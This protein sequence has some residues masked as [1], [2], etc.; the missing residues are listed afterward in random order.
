MEALDSDL[1]EMCCAAAGDDGANLWAHV[2]RRAYEAVRA[3]WCGGWLSGPRAVLSSAERFA[4]AESIGCPWRGRALMETAARAGAL[5]VLRAVAP[6]YTA[7]P[8]SAT[9]AA[10][11]ADQLEVLLAHDPEPARGLLFMAGPRVR[12]HYRHLDVPLRS[13]FTPGS[14]RHS[15]FNPGFYDAARDFRRLLAAA[16]PIESVIA[17]RDWNDLSGD[18]MRQIRVDLG[19]VHPTVVVRSRITPSLRRV[20]GRAGWFKVRAPSGWH[21]IDDVRATVG[22]IRG[23]D[24]DLG[25][26]IEPFEPDRAWFTHRMIYYWVT[27]WIEAPAD[28]LAIGITFRGALVPA[29]ELAPYG[30]G[31]FATDDRIVYVSEEC[32]AHMYHLDQAPLMRADGSD[33]CAPLLSLADG[34]FDG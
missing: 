15:P 7:W 14:F 1:L 23:Y 8:D 31:T 21:I 19:P 28:T 26:L 9:V 34:L 11:K 18:R 12:A 16:V 17:P 29:P 4:W 6:L 5:D 33:D 27:F 22:V 3:V 32:V 24:L 2:S 10:A 25:M 30:T 20:D 13:P